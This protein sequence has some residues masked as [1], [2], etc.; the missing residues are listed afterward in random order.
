MQRD[1]IGE[2]ELRSAQPNNSGQRQSMAH[3]IQDVQLPSPSIVRGRVVIAFSV[4]A[5][6]AVAMTKQLACRVIA[7]Y[8]YQ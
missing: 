4:A 1:G 5:R 8:L 6:R 2:R 7:R 3:K